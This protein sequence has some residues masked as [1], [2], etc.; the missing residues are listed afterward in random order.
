MK[1]QWFQNKGF[2]YNL[3]NRR[4]IIR[5]IATTK[6]N[7]QFDDTQIENFLKA[8]S[9]YSHTMSGKEG[10]VS[11][12]G[13]VNYDEDLPLPSKSLFKF[14]PKEIFKNFIK[15]GKF[16]LGSLQYYREIENEKIKDKKEGYSNIIIN[17]D[18]RQLLASVI[19]GFNYYIF[20][21][22]DK[23]DELEYKSA[24][25]GGYIMKINNIKSFA[26]KVMKAIGAKSWST[27]KVFYSDF[28]A[29]KVNADVEMDGA[30]P[31]LSEELFN[32]LIEISELPSVFGKPKS[33]E[34]EQEVR[35]AFDMGSVTKRKKLNFDN[36]GLLEEIKLVNTAS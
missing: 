5:A 23:L 4:L 24:N 32:K 1:R 7:A 10:K 19:S 28:K 31:N 11:L 34:P 15:K 25:F 13:E 22:T 36:L 30:N 17:T 3:N 9:Q 26:T 21:G 6:E 8:I 35:V 29:Y 27:R 20:C 33:F 16:Q 12:F 14:I 18:N 2:E